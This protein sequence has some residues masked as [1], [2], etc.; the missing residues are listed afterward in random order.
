MKLQPGDMV[1]IQNHTKGPFDLKYIGD[2]RVVSLKGNQVEIQPAIRGST[3]IKHIK[4]AKYV[5]PTD[6]YINQLPSYSQFGR[7]TT[8]RINPDQIPDLHWKLVDTYHTTNIGQTEVKDNTVHNITLN[9]HVNTDNIILS[10]KT[11][12]TQSRREPLVF[13]VLPIT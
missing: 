1:L 11:H 8:L 4:H 3:E 2:Y 9:T 7:K 6:K 13:S 10:T 12:T 5:L